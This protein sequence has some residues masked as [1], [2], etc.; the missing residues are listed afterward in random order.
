MMLNADL[1]STIEGKRKRNPVSV[2]ADM[3]RNLS[4]EKVTEISS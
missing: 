3:V 4:E 1:Q 2:S